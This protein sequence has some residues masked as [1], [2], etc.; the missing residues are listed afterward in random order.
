MKQK[1]FTFLL[2]AATAL[3]ACKKSDSQPD[4]RAYD[5]EQIKNY[6][7]AN[8]LTD[9]TE[10]TTPDGSGTTGIHYKI[11]S[12]GT[13]DTLK[14]A[15]NIS[16]VYTVKS[17]DGKFVRADTI[18]NHYYGYLGYLA[19]VT[20]GFYPPRGLQLA[21]HDLL[22]HKGAS[23]RVIIPSR[24]GY[25]TSGFGSGSASN[26]NTR[27]AG[28]QSLDCYVNV[29]GDQDAYDDKV[30]TQY[31]ATNNLAGF[32]KDPLGY[33]YK[34]VTQGTA[35]SISEFSKLTLTYGG[36]LLNTFSFDYANYTTSV[37]YTPF[38]FSDGGFYGGNGVEAIKHAL[39]NHA[40]KGT[41]LQLLIPSRL[42]LGTS[43]LTTIPPNS[44]LKFDFTITDIDAVD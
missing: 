39:I 40:T 13:G 7:A 31:I 6:I 17:L 1:I 38:D 44:I 11:I 23:M 41:S 29:I 18:V 43:A 27:V 28:N 3:T 8:G 30:I 25:G 33:Y 21:I 32:T 19:T 37:V 26:T 15:D 24:L 2:I 14:Y 20:T 4:I 22:Q 10:D 5:Q 9:F 16:L 34:T 42:G 36:S 12:P 35:G